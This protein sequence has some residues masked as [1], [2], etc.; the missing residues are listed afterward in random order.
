MAETALRA[1][2]L[3]ALWWIVTPGNPLKDVSGLAPLGE[4]LAASRALIEDPRI[5]VTAFEAGH[6][7]RRTADTLRLVRARRPGLRLVWVMGADNLSSFH[8]WGEWVWIARNVPV[9]VVDRPGS[10]LS[11][12]ASRF[13][14]RFARHRVPEEAAAALPDR[15]PPAWTFLHGPRSGLSSTALRAGR[16]P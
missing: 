14:Q 7:V 13:A 1:L 5:R 9:A 15:R 12:V 10:T 16:G 8:R 4:R 3:Q 6:R 11:T 2:R